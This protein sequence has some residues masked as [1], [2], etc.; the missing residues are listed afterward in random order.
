MT[1]Y[2]KTMAEAWN[3]SILI[4][5]GLMGTIKPDQLDNIKKVWAKKSMKDV[6]PGVRAMLAKLDMPTK[7]AVKHA[8]INVLSK[9]V[10][11][12]KELEEQTE[13][14]EGRMKDIFTADQEGKSAEEI[15]KRLKISV[16]TVKDILGV[17]EQVAI[18]EGG[19]K[20]ALMDVEDDA[21]RMDL[22]KFI[23]KHYGTMGLSAQELKKIFYR[24]NNEETELTEIANF[25]ASMI[26][27][28]KKEYEPMRGKKITAARAKQLMNILDKLN[29][30]NLETLSKQNIPFVSSGSASKLAVR[31][32]KFKVTNVNPFKEEVESIDEK[33]D[34]FMLSYSD[35]YGK[36]AGFEG[37]KTLQDLQNKAANLRKK[38]FKIDKMGRYN[39]PVKEDIQNEACWVGYKQVGMKN[40][41]GKEVPNCVPEDKEL[42]E[43]IEEMAKDDAY[44]IGMAAA[45]KHT[46]DTE[47]PL[48]KSTITKGHEIAKKILKKE[49]LDESTK[50]V[51][52]KADKS[53]MPY[54]VLK[55]VYDRGM[56][57]WK[58][59]HRPG[60]TQV[61]W[62]LARVNSF[63][64]KGS[65]TWGGADKDL[66]KQ[67]RSEDL[68]A[69]PQDGDVKKK[70]G[71]QPKKYYK[72]LSKSEKGKR[73]DY[74]KNND[75][76]KPAPGD[77]DAKTKPSIHTNKYKKMYGEGAKQL[78]DRILKEKM[79]KNK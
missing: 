25:T 2:R 20:A 16:K 4:E 44:A 66:A 74:F 45:K 31:K 48:E 65:G 64:T 24:V 49:D 29:D 41:G 32:M 14:D 26:N 58:G 56:A 37:A 61:Q 11:D 38:G 71:T 51:R 62:A 36:H 75:S 70:D 40:K 27:V 76:N 35:R 53:K 28:L 77:K 3:E 30:K 18:D 10:L 39:P 34:P 5:S 43:H 6:T 79:E 21:T 54:S 55:K 69:V 60:A 8:N 47:P 9:L 67:V 46:G 15:A 13:L 42:E 68:R 17:K 73:A 1:R 57:A 33:I 72:G 22:N 12:E 63:I 23:R 50:A 78:V 7:V 59:G 52:K 19:V